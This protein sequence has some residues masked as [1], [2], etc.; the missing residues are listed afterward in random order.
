MIPGPIPTMIQPN[1]N[2][3]I[4]PH[5]NQPVPV[6]FMGQI[7]MMPQIGM[8]PQFVVNMPMAQN[9]QTQMFIPQQI[10]KTE[11]AATEVPNV[12]QQTP[13]PSSQPSPQLLPQP[14]PQPIP[15]PVPQ[16]IPQPAPQQTSQ[17]TPQPTPQPAPLADQIKKAEVLD[18]KANKPLV[19]DPAP[20]Q[21]RLP[22]DPAITMINQQE[23]NA[24]VVV[25]KQVAPTQERQPEPAVEGQNSAST[26]PERNQ[27]EKQQEESKPN[28]DS[29]LNE[30]N[31][32]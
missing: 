31:Q 21:A 19:A 9:F 24:P 12:E 14:I 17:P 7:I 23:V 10:P 25:P 11:K 3:Y 27:S 16:S 30:E 2:A 32:K 15:Q 4:A 26:E 6:Q 28:D 1:F 20:K 13:Q 29:N 18:E 8:R 5:P 22:P